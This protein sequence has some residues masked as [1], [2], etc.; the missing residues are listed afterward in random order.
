MPRQSQ[1]SRTPPPP[2]HVDSRALIET[3][4]EHLLIVRG[5][6]GPNVAWE[7]PGGRNR[8]EESPEAALRR[9]CLAQ[10]GVDLDISIGQ[11]PFDYEYADGL[12]RFRYYMCQISHGDAQPVGCAEVRAVHVR[13][14]RDYIF[15]DAAAKVVEWLLAAPR[16]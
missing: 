6:P 15:E 16:D 4:P 3:R 13:Q 12:V 5:S 7:F 11:P 2:T 10:L 8:P 1:P 9:V 14:L